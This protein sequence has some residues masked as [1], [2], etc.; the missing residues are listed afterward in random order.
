MPFIFS[1]SCDYPPPKL[2]IPKDQPLPDYSKVM[3]YIDFESIT[4]HADY[5][6]QA[7]KQSYLKRILSKIFK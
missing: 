6:Y 1:D 5:A 2:T 7:P 3:K 4:L